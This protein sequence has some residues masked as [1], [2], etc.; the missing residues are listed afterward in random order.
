MANKFMASKMVAKEEEM[1]SVMVD[2]LGKIITMTVVSNYWFLAIILISYLKKFQHAALQ[3]AKD[4]YGED[5]FIEML[6]KEEA[7]TYRYLRTKQLKN[8]LRRR[9]FTVQEVWKP[10]K[11]AHNHKLTLILFRQLSSGS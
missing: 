5:C 6:G 2:P 4:K 9:V 8:R 10:N 7:T 3:Y 11:L 1:M